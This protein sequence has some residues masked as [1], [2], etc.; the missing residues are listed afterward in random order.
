MK[1]VR[2][3]LFEA[4]L[5]LPQE[6]IDKVNKEAREQYGQGPTQRDFAEM[7]RLLN[8]IFSIQRGHEDALTELGKRIIR[9]FYGPVIEKVELDVKIV[10]PEDEEKNEMAQKMLGEMPEQQEEDQEDAEVELELPGIEEDIDKRKLI[11]NIMQ[12]EAQ[13]VHDMM[14]D[15]KDEVEEITGSNRLLDLY[16]EF[17]ELNKKFDWDDR[18]NLEEMMQQ[19]PQMA[20][21]METDWEEGEEG[22]GD[23]PKIKARVLDLP[24]LVHETV[25][26]IYE[27][28]VSGAINPDPVRAQKILKATDSLSDEQQDIRYG[29]YIAKDLRDYVNNAADEISGAYDIPNMRE[30]VFGKMIELPSGEFVRLITAILMKEEWPKETI[31][32]FISDI[33]KDFSE[34]NQAQIPGYEDEDEELP[35]GV[36]EYP[37]EDEEEKEND[38][39]NL[40]KGGK[41][42]DNFEKEPEDISK[43]LSS[44]GKNALNVELNKAIDNED[45][46][47]AKQIQQMIDRKGGISNEGVSQKFMSIYESEIKNIINDINIF[48]SSINNIVKDYKDYNLSKEDYEE[49]IEQIRGEIEFWFEN[50]DYNIT[51]YNMAQE[52]YFN[53]DDKIP[54]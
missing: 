33:Q 4:K 52:F 2:E 37:E 51:N 42:P 5:N 44:M 20:N 8:E 46:E 39:I 11:N 27:L 18:L 48:K 41:K 25:K 34:Y 53:W 31:I 54:Y 7:G 21:A 32:K 13:N 6:Y 26:G 15:M 17:L 28:I 22:E 24:M 9:K 45:W 49:E 35:A 16:M 10:D 47:L 12:G 19:A 1:P 36:E 30:F 23:T 50:L 40:M 43:K 3:N 29:P 14:Y 38:L